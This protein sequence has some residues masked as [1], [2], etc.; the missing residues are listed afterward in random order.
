MWISK[1]NS[2]SE[3]EKFLY[4]ERVINE[5]SFIENQKRPQERI[6]KRKF[7]SVHI[8]C[9]D[10]ANREF[11]AQISL[12]SLYLCVISRLVELRGH[13]VAPIMYK[14]DL[15]L[16]T[17]FTLPRFWMYKYKKFYDIHGH[18]LLKTRATENPRWLVFTKLKAI[19]NSGLNLT[20]KSS[21]FFLYTMYFLKVG[22][23]KDAW[24]WFACKLHFLKFFSI[25][26]LVENIFFLNLVFSEDESI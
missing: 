9:R 24:F 6:K 21:C 16:S 22:W 14:F 25:V 10:L 20:L 19:P 7:K 18:K 4:F 8:R 3:A 2:Q 11:S 26:W 15:L 17:V 13:K 12:F 23:C 1:S 5:S